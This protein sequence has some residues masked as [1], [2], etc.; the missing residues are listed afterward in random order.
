MS[1]IITENCP[2]RCPQTTKYSCDTFGRCFE[3]T[4]GPFSTLSACH[5][6]VLNGLCGTPKPTA[7]QGPTATP[8]PTSLP[9]SAPGA[10]S[11]NYNNANGTR[12]GASSVSKITTVGTNGGPS[13]YGTYDQT[14]NVNEIVYYGSSSTT[15][16]GGSWQSSIFDCASY[17]STRIGSVTTPRKILS[18]TVG[19]DITNGFRLCLNKLQTPIHEIDNSRFCLVGPD[20][21]DNGREIY[22]SQND[23][24]G[25]GGVGFSY[26]IGKY[27][28]TNCEYV[29][30]LNAVARFDITNYPSP[31]YIE[32]TTQGTSFIQNYGILRSGSSSSYSYYVKSGYENKPVIAVSCLNAARYCNWLSLGKPFVQR[33]SELNGNDA[34]TTAYQITVSTDG[35]ST[36]SIRY[37]DSRHYRLPTETEW[38][39]AAYYNPLKDYK[40]NTFA[41]QVRGNYVPSTTTS[42]GVIL[43]SIT[44]APSTISANSNGDGPLPVNYSCP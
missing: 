35:L 13:Y 32:P 30:F 12:W 10:N 7:T 23:F 38:Y 17:Y 20:S 8:G 25:L 5:Q 15:S 14:G 37:I 43:A 18:T 33:V 40:Y 2:P 9:P 1:T 4:N 28:V 31:L 29:Q 19:Y 22:N 11:A 6:A 41:T 24:S 39:K 34:N 26:Y 36:V 21:I 27:P 42:N 44:N 3:S 16:K